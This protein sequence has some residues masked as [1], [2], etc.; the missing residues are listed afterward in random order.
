M[1]ERTITT[2]IGYRKKVVL[3]KK[4]RT[5]ARD[6]NQCDVIHSSYQLKTKTFKF[7]A[8]YTWETS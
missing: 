4:G 8:I 5:T 3:S 7:R 2:P 6:V 1:G